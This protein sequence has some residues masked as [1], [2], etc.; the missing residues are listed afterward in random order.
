MKVKVAVRCADG[1]PDLDTIGAVDVYCVLALGD[2][3]VQTVE[4]PNTATPSWNEEFEL[5]TQDPENDSVRIEL[6]DADP[7]RDEA[8][9]VAHA[10]VRLATKRGE[11]MDHWVQVS[12][13]KATDS[14]RAL[15]SLCAVDFGE[16]NESAT[17]TTAEKTSRRPQP[18][19]HKFEVRVCSAH[20]LPDADAFGK[21][22]P[23]C[24][25]TCG[26]R[27][28]QTDVVEDAGTDVQ[29]DA[30]TEF[31]TR[32]V[33]Q[34][35]V[36]AQVFDRDTFSDDALGSAKISGLS[37]MVREAWNDV[38]VRLLGT[39]H[40]GARLHVQVRPLTFGVVPRPA[41]DP[42]DF[43]PDAAFKQACEKLSIDPAE[44]KPKPL[45]HFSGKDV[46]DD[47]ARSRFATHQSN[48]IKKLHAVLVERK[49]LIS[50]CATAPSK[51]APVQE[52][53]EATCSDDE[54]RDK[55]I[56]RAK[57]QR[58]VWD[59]SREREKEAREKR[60]QRDRQTV[61]EA[62]KFAEEERQRRE[63]HHRQ[64]VELHRAN[65]AL[66][67]KRWERDEQLAAARQ[68]KIDEEA[69]AKAAAW[70]NHMASLETA[71]L[72]R[73]QHLEATAGA[74]KDD[75]TEGRLRKARELR[76]QVDEDIARRTENTL[77]A[78]DRSR[79]KHTY[80]QFLKQ[81]D[82]AN[83]ALKERETIE[84]T[85]R[86]SEEVQAKRQEAISARMRG[87]EAKHAETAHHNDSSV[88]SVTREKTTK[89]EE[90]HN[91]ARTARLARE[92]TKARKRAELAELQRQKDEER[93]ARL[94]VERAKHQDRLSETNQHQQEV[95]AR[96]ARDAERQQQERQRK[97]EAQQANAAR[98]MRRMNEI[99]ALLA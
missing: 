86:R 90:R 94:E 39:K 79:E 73:S 1:V 16:F 76:Q 38:T 99:H 51:A 48:L 5:E 27:V 83:K 43:E 96:V 23:F 2:Q 37:K 58:G 89:R 82:L 63:E 77:A 7:G 95:L 33:D 56:E 17:R 10:A 88:Q 22:D 71:R 42:V 74:R 92:E 75:N 78:V 52:E 19:T 59:R 80:E 9:G 8:I 44:L 47:V 20:G 66:V 3:R 67:Q 35:E 28:W 68:R 40:S 15:V 72:R 21:I 69:R 13:G 46:S 50:E 87:R 4:Q 41:R 36:K 11:W 32:A 49:R 18:P 81:V 12:G 30:Q 53:A 24:R 55:M 54:E 14:T 65:Q 97:L 6:F 91:N 60:L 34:C 57:H 45:E 70:D 64:L 85:L 31:G 29:W 98:R 84:A 26:K 61:E 25:L 93:K 62:A